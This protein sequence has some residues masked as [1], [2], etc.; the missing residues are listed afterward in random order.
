MAV[1]TDDGEQSVDA[2]SAGHGAA[3]YDTVTVRGESEPET[4]LS[5]PLHGRR[6]Q[7]DDLHRQLEDWVGRGV[8]EPSAAEAVRAELS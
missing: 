5:L 8:M 3:A 2:W 4:A 6:L 1:A 7:G